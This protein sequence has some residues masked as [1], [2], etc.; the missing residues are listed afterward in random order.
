M[1]RNNKVLKHILILL[2]L[3][4][5]FLML[6][7]GVLSLTSPDEV[8]YTQTAKEMIQQKTWMTPYI[9]AEP[10]FEKPILIYWLLRV[11]FIIF[12]VT[13]FAARFFPA[14]FAILGV[15]AVYFFSLIA[16]KDE[17]KAFLSSLI[18]A[19]CGLY[20]GLARSVFTDL[21]FTVFIL[22]ALVSFYW[23][24]AD[25]RR[26]DLGIILFF[27]F[28]GLAVLTKGPLGILI[29]FMPVFTFLFIRKE[30]KFLAAKSL[31]AGIIIFILISFPWYILMIVKYGRSF[32]HEF[33]YNDHY[34]RLIEAEHA[35]NDSWYFYPFSIFAC[36]FPW[37]L[38]AFASLAALIRKAGKLANPVYV[39]LL[40]WIGW[41]LLVFQPAHSKLVSYI[42]PCFPAL[43]VITGDYIYNLVYR[44]K[45]SRLF[46]GFS[47]TMLLIMLAI[48]V[49]LFAAIN[50]FS[51]YVTSRASVYIVIPAL[52]ILAVVYAYFLFRQKQFHVLIVQSMFVPLLIFGLFLGHKNAEPYF[53]LRL[54]CEY[55]SEKGQ[56][57][58]PIITSKSFC[59]GV[60]FYTGNDVVIAD[61]E[62]NNFFSPHPLIFLDTQK[63]VDDFLS[64]YPEAYCIVRKKDVG[65][66][67]EMAG[68][69]YNLSPLKVIGNTYILKIENP[70]S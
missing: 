52:F 8:F 6:G 29:T 51:A 58:S 59:R 54:S 43:A 60:R 1:Y 23:G 48:P 4:Y 45:K 11:A 24:Y 47:L 33:F 37:S 21:I 55:L 13:A 32:T 62:A 53:S 63:K 17:D 16:F 70:K 66:L 5:I 26:K 28:S 9:F 39:F 20:I 64:K 2:G 12:G 42:F 40:S 25:R 15:M 65:F 10:Q 35:S 69:K 38:F 68:E 67:K 44:E 50:I 3:C 36:I 56:V 41:V 30:L 49:G 27:V 19:S 18:L 61:S 46:F 14:L 34:R 31:L 22:F 7:N 57:A